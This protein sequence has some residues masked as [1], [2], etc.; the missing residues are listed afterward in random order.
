MN[1]QT[2]FPGLG[3]NILGL[4]TFFTMSIALYMVF[5]WSPIEKV[6]REVQKIFYFHVGTAWVGFFAFFVVFVCSIMYLK[7]KE[8]K[9]DIIA[10]SA[11][12]IGV[13][14]ITLVI[15][16]G[17]IWA[18]SAWN[19]WWTWE[20]R[21]TTSL[22]L[23]FIY[24]AYVLVRASSVENEKKARLSA[25]F[26][27]IGFVD[28]PIVFLSIKWWSVA[29]PFLIENGKMSLEPAMFQTLMVSVLAFTLLFFYLLQKG[30]AIS[31]AQ[32]E[33]NAIKGKLREKYN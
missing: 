16:T 19:T 11:A 24:I 2:G 32:D 3:H 5:I 18:K 7:T 20:P 23:W 27:I 22:I 26:G 12:E 15:I 29:H 8:R 4:I 28:V 21:L 33:V 25:I 17:P 10:A 13:V 1:K 9:W 31:K 14:F 6:M 30:I